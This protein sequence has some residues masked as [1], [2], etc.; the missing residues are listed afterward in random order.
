M[1]IEPDDLRRVIEDEIA[2]YIQYCDVDPR[3]HARFVAFEISAEIF[4]ALRQIVPF[5]E[6]E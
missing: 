6:L 5:G 2:R 4:R 3:P 1:N